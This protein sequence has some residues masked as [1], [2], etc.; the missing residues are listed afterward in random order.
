[1]LFVGGAG[2]IALLGCFLAAR[3]LLDAV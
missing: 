1:V 3:G 2:L